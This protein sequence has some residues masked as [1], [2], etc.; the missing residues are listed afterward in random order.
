MRPYYLSS[1]TGGAPTCGR[2]IIRM[3]VSAICELVRAKKQNLADVLAG[4]TDDQ[5]AVLLSFVRDALQC[6]NGRGE[7]LDSKGNWILGASLAG[8]AAVTAA[9]KP[10]IDGL[11]GWGH[12]FVLGGTLLIVA[13]LIIAGMFVLAGIRVRAA[14]FPLN[15]ELII[16]REILAAEPRY[17]YRDLVLHYTEVFMANWRVS[18][19]KAD[20]LTC[21]QF[22]LLAAFAVAVIIGLARAF[23]T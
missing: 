1:V 9:A 12:D 22:S 15:P 10:V 8:L 5:G 7:H 23:L 17:L 19:E 2:I 11:H 3:K 18:E 16:R 14:W 6:E 4:V 21:G 20:M 13:A